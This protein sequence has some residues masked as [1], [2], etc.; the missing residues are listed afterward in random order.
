MRTQK[1]G[2]TLKQAAYAR[3]IWGA[4]GQN[5]KQIALDV[6]YTPSVANSC[7]SKIEDRPGFNNAIA[8]LATESHNV[9]IAVLHEFKAR[10][11]KDF[12]DKD[13]ISSLNAISNAWDKFNKGLIQAEK[14]Q[15]NG[16]NRLRTIVL[17]RS[18]VKD[19]VS[20]QPSA[21][22]KEIPK[23]LDF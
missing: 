20:N 2:S 22:A 18:E 10:G 1:N 12:S 8:K 21:T 15:D 3:R 7:V 6:G 4:E 13:L 23:D 11:V 17:T 14:P 16:K 5:K 9:A 19:V